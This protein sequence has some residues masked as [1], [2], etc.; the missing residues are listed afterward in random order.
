MNSVI[1]K[2]CRQL[3][4]FSVLTLDPIHKDG[5]RILARQVYRHR[6]LVGG[7]IVANVFS[8]LFEG[9]TIAILALAVTALIGNESSATSS[10]LQHL[11]TAADH[12]GFP[13]GRGGLFLV[14][15][16]TAII[17]QI[18]KSGCRYLAVVFAIKLQI[19]V[20]RSL[21]ERATDQIM[22]FSYS[23][24]SRHPAGTLSGLIGH[25][26]KFASLIS[27]FNQVI[28]AA[29]MLLTYATM[30]LIMSPL[31]STAAIIV[32]ILLSLALTRLISL[33]RTL[34]DQI[35][36][37][38]LDHSKITFEYLSVP[39][40]LR[41]FDATRTAA[42]TIN[43]VRAGILEIQQRTAT[44]KAALEPAIDILTIVGAGVFLIAGYLIA[45]D[46]ATEVIPKLLLFLFVLNRMMPQMKTL[47]QS[48]LVFASM[49]KTVELTAEFLQTENKQFIRIGGTKISGL[50]GNISFENVS[51][52]YPGA[53]VSV[54]TDVSFTIPKGNTIA[55]VG[56]SGAGKSTITDLL[57]GLYEPTQGKITVDG[58][59]LSEIDLSNWL[60]HLGVVDQDVVLLNSSVKENILLTGLLRTDGDA[61]DAARSAHAHD[62]ISS[63][64]DGYDTVIGDRGYRLSGG[65]QQRLALARA[66]VRN[67]EILILDEATSALDSESEQLIQKAI[68]SIS[69]SRTMLIVAHRLSTILEAD[70][71][72]VLEDGKIVEKGTANELLQK[73]K[74]FYELAS[75]QGLTE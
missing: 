25:T 40:L 24:I 19:R 48:R 13:L 11:Q 64:T 70:E 46:H 28:L 60:S 27:L 50:R 31:L 74:R 49:L 55:I 6:Y 62:F 20:S 44:L 43:R 39:R 12:I 17:A 54:L 18:W 3:F 7:I 33:L 57:L 66:L 52:K 21:Q 56:P 42:E 5:L 34:G 53:D 26:D 14:L 10:V 45:G 68:R 35:A 8:A 65:Q 22:S 69:E 37:G 41:V 30:L 72:I 23:E 1:V 58:I 71:I 16:L 36:M 59:V 9:G 63:M 67:A 38:V 29:F 75:L 4:L 47:N 61:T 73:H 15:I 51:F 32:V 2:A